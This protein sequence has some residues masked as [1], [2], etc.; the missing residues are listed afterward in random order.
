MMRILRPRPGGDEGRGAASAVADRPWR[1]SG[2][3][4]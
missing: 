3:A 2:R 4:R 1:V